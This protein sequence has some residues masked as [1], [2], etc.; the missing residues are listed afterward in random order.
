MVSAPGSNIDSTS[1]ELISNNGSTFGSNYNTAEGTSFAAPIVSGVVALMLEAN[2]KLGW[3]DI[4][5]ILAMTANAM[6]GDRDEYLAAGMDDYI[7]KPFRLAQLQELLSRWLPTV[8][9]S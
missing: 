3:R 9:Q 8:E 1:R 7:A 5:S 2:P 4:Q 6:A